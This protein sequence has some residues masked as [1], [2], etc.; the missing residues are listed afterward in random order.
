VFIDPVAD[1]AVLSEP[2]GQELFNEH[3][4]YEALTDPVEPFLLGTLTFVQQE[5]QLPNGNIIAREAE[6]RGQMLS[7]D[8]RWFACMV[9]SYGGRA[10]AVEHHHRG[11]KKTCGSA[12]HPDGVRWR[13][14]LT[15]AVVVLS[16][17]GGMTAAVCAAVGVSRATVHRARAVLTTPPVLSLPRSRPARALTEPQQKTVLDVL[18]APRFADQA[19]A[20]IY[21]TLLDEGVYHCSIRTMY[22]IL[23]RQGEIRERR[24]QLRHPVYQKPE[25]LAERPN[26]VWSWDITKLMGPAKWSY[27]YLYVILDIYSRRVVGWCVADAESATLFQPLFDDAIEKHNVPPGQLTLHADRGAPMKAKATAFLLADLGV[28]RS[29]NRPHTSNDNPFSESHFKT[30]KYQP[31]FPKRF[32]CIEDARSFCRQFFDWYNQDHHHAGI[33][34]M[35]PDQVHYGQI[36]AVHAARQITLDQAFREYPERFVNKAPTPPDKP[37][38]TWINPPTPKVV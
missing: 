13:R 24:R 10:A 30:L 27:F 9:K 1:I 38:A 32:G 2:D 34:L 5:R 7:L 3:E 18:H 35:T 11:P 33:G 25:L 37:T 15:Q 20:E 19:P 17:A 14:A 8:R 12:G 26:E 16:P 31:R 21:A 4:A 6:A 23:D 28:T 36:D 22:R 29:H